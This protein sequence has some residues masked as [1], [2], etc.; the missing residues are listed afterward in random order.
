MTPAG[1]VVGEVG[2]AR[3]TVGAVLAAEPTPAEVA[4]AVGST[5]TTSSSAGAVVLAPARA[6][7]RRRTSA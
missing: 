6:A 2:A 1:R 7:I 5:T 3:V 4:S